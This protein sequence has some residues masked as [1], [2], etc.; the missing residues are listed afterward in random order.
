M[1]EIKSLMF[2][3]A[4]SVLLASSCNYSFTGASISPEVKTISISYFRNEASLINPTL[5][6][7]FTE[8]IKDKFLSQTTLVL[9]DKDGDLQLEGS[10]T[11]YNTQPIAIQTNERA[12]LNRLTISISV[13]YSNKFDEKHNFEQIFSRYEDYDSKKNLR[14][15]EDALV[16]LINDALVEDIFNKA[17]VNW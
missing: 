10:I 8:A 11:D 7:N 13:K 1:K 15:V 3:L 6:Q 5:S 12:A 14:E 16:K 2:F 9:K 17:V 4:I